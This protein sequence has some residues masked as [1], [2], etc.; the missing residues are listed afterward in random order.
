MV[1][2]QTSVDRGATATDVRR[3]PRVAA[4]VLRDEN[5]ALLDAIVGRL[6]AILDVATFGRYAE[7]GGEEEAEAY[8]NAARQRNE[9]RVQLERRIAALRRAATAR[10]LLFPLD[11]LRERFALDDFETEVLCFALAPVID[12]SFRKRIARFKDNILLDYTDADL[13]CGLVFPDRVERLRARDYFLR[14]GRLRRHKLVEMVHPKDVSSEQLLSDEIRLPSRVTNFLLGRS[15]LDRTIAELAT[16]RDPSAT[17]DDV[18]LAD[19]VLA[20]VRTVVSH[21][22]ATNADEGAMG[23]GALVLQLAGA[24]GTGKSLLAEAIAHRLGRKLLEVDC[25]RIGPPERSPNAVLGE[26]FYAAGVHGAVLCLDHC[27]AVFGE[28]SARLPSFFSLFE[29]F[30]GLVVLVTSEPKKLDFTLERWVAVSLKIE[31]PEGPLRERIWKNLLP[32]AVPLA[33]DVDLEDLASLFEISGG[34]I[35]NAV[36]LAVKRSFGD[37]SGRNR[38]T[39]RTLAEA[40]HAQL[41]A[42]MDDYS[43]KSHVGLSLD[44][45]VLPPDV[46]VQI[47]HVLDAAR[48]RTFVMNK[49]GFGKRLVTG[50]GIVFMLT[51]E[52]GTGKTLCAEILAAELELNLYRVSIPNI[53]SKYIGETEKNISK[54]FAAARASQSMLLFDEA[55]ALFAKR[56]KVERSVDRFSNMEV[57]LLLQEI[58]RFEGIVILTTNLERD[59]DKAF[60]RRINFKTRFPFPDAEHREKIWRILIPPEC[61]LG[62]DVDFEALAKAFELTGGYIKNV[63]LRAAYRAAKTR[64]PITMEHF[65]LAAEAECQQAGK[66]YRDVREFYADDYPD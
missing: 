46:F 22:E 54:I 3:A 36:R 14:D 64:A 57:N 44:H 39:Q 29:T 62:D 50:K 40:A 55:D 1:E 43:F 58:E 35:R 52:P 4:D 19:E 25:T 16:L 42:D 49:W 30:S 10:G 12:L 6:E 65:R 34:A 41:R 2:G 15:G 48:H 61:P 23:G 7:S 9:E 45:I 17:L 28:S 37:A 11:E 32:E 33:E 31:V 27:E 21:Q 51:G 5:L 20:G 66:L 47:E 8:R 53:M 18:V 24:P 38:V 63:I 60:Q 56:V 26:I 59:L 13:I